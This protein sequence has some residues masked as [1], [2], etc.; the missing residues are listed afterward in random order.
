MYTTLN[1]DFLYAQ[2]DEEIGVLMVG[3]ADNEFDTQEYVLLQKTLNPSED[4]V[5]AG[6]DK[7]HITYNDELQ[8]LYGG[9]TKCYFTRNQ[10]EITLNEEAT[11]I[12][13]SKPVIVIKYD[14]KNLDI[15]QFHNYLLQLFS[16][17]QDVYSYDI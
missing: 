17:E 4:D 7:V 8:S 1:A 12:L 10:I 5:V 3:F 14:Q 13:N 2:I 15:N 9:I 16:S 11:E 6:F